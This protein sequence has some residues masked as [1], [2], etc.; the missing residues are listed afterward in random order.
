[1]CADC[2]HLK[3]KLERIAREK[4][5]LLEPLD[6]DEIGGITPEDLAEMIE[7]YDEVIQDCKKHFTMHTDAGAPSADRPEESREEQDADRE[8]E[9][10]K[11]KDLRGE[12]GQPITAQHN[13]NTYN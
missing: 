7:G 6:N 13:V 5:E 2:Y 1:M 11:G 4:A 8:E 10:Q 9:N 3:L 12:Q